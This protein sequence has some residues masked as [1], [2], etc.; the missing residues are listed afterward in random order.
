MFFPVGD[1]P[2]EGRHK[3]VFAYAFLVVN[4]LIFF[5]QL[6]L[7]GDDCNNFMR[8]FGAIPAEITQGKDLF[9][10]FTSIFL[11]AGFMH[12]LGNM[13]FLWVFA[14][15]IESLVGNLNF[16][17]F[18]LLG[19]IVA[20]L[21]HVLFNWSSEIPTVGASGAI[22]AVLGAYIVLYPKSKI[23]VRFLLFKPFTMSALAFLGIWFAQ[24]LFSG[25][26][27]LG[28]ESAQSGGVAWWAHIGGFLFGVICGFLA[29]QLYQDSAKSYS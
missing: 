10:L 3:P 15:N 14:D 4:V 11:H 1:D 16:I 22:A 18:Y 24:N 7:A 17:I 26:G 5:Y 29:K 27:S 6:S 21:I 19:G 25:L 12:I 28:P 20:S 2:N 23:K 13:I 9:S 8:H